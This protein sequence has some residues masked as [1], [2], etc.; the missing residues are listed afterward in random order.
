MNKI[1]N[2]QLE[3]CRMLMEELSNKGIAPR[4]AN[5]K[6]LYWALEELKERR[7]KDEKKPKKEK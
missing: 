7:A 6:H 1:T 5:S 3:E 4:G 2:A